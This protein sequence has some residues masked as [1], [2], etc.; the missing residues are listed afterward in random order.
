LVL[1]ELEGMT[2]HLTPDGAYGADARTGLYFR[3]GSWPLWWFGWLCLGRGIRGGRGG[4]CLLE[5]GGGALQ[6]ILDF[7]EIVVFLHKIVTWP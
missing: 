3:S 1:V 4:R 7:R 2:D 5:K 6:L